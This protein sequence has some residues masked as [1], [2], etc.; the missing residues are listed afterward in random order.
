MIR[1]FTLAKVAEVRE[2]YPAT[3][4]V[5][6]TPEVP[7]HV[8]RLLI[9]PADPLPVVWRG[10]PTWELALRASHWRGRKQRH[11]RRKLRTIDARERAAVRWA[12]RFVV[13]H[14][15]HV[16]IDPQILPY[17]DG[18]AAEVLAMFDGATRVSFRPKG[19]QAITIQLAQPRPELLD[20][21][22]QPTRVSVV[23][24]GTA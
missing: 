19:G 4:E 18:L 12:L 5:Q 11:A 14:Q 17:N 22:A 15:V 1:S 9:L 20:E 6:F 21:P 13:L 24:M 16:G 8:D 10:A 2:P 3:T 23:I 7:L